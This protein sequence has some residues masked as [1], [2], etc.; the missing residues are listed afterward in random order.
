M[1][2]NTI[3]NVATLQDTHT[4]IGRINQNKV[5]GVFFFLLFPFQKEAKQTH[6]FPGR[7]QHFPFSIQIKGEMTGRTQCWCFAHQLCR[8]IHTKRKTNGKWFRHVSHS[9]LLSYIWFDVP[10]VFV[11][12]FFKHQTFATVFYRWG[13]EVL[14]NV[15]VYQNAK[16][17]MMITNPAFRWLS[18]PIQRNLEMWVFSSFL[19]SVPQYK[20]RHWGCIIS[21]F[22]FAFCESSRTV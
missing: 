13:G 21:I 18:E 6:L 12:F 15:R 3:W 9:R 22:F 20:I 8:G 19:P 16:I 4:S 11:F 17:L 14:I 7:Q 2:A 5:A 1:F 10:R